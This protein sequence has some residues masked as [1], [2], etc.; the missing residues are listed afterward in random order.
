MIRALCSSS[1]IALLF[2]WAV[3]SLAD[4][5]LP[6]DLTTAPPDPN[7]RKE[8]AAFSGKWVGKW[9][10]L[11][12]A[13]LIV[14]EI[15]SKQAKVIYAWGDALQWNT[16]KGYARF[17]ATVIPTDNGAFDFQAGSSSFHV[18]MNSDL[19]TVRI[20]R[21]AFTRTDIETFKRAAP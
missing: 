19:A 15:D 12:D 21:V 13:V 11:L 2:L 9:S 14:E 4:V 10:G 1:G 17:V 20:T 18:Q 7:L 5:P 3:V 16:K 6:S 8:L